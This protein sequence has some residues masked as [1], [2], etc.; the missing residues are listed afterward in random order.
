MDKKVD[1]KTLLSFAIK[2]KASDL[3][4]TT[5]TVPMLRLNGKIRTIQ[6][7]AMTSEDVTDTLTDVM[8][9]EQYQEFQSEQEI[10][11]A[12]D[13][14][15]GARFRVNAFH[16]I[17]GPAA[18]FR[19]I[20][21]KVPRLDDL[22]TPEIFKKFASLDKGLILVTGATGFGKSTTLAAM[23]D[24]INE[25][26]AKHILT[27]EDPVEFIH[28]PKNCLINHREVGGST[29]SFSKA[30]KSALRESPDVILVGEMRDLE[31]ISLALTAAETGHLVLGTLHT[32]SAP[33]TINRIIDVFPSGDKTM[34]RSM[35]ASSLQAV[36]AQT[37]LPTMDKKGR[38]AAF[39]VLVCNS[40]V[41]NLIREDQIPQIYSIMQVGHR[42]GMQT[43]QKAIEDLVDEK[44]V[45]PSELDRFSRKTED[46]E[47]S[48]VKKPE[49][50]EEE[51][52]QEKIE[53]VIRDN[54][55]QE[56][57]KPTLD[58]SKIAQ[59]SLEEDLDETI[60]IEGA[61]SLL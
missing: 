8:N 52:K 6:V 41:R 22:G 54:R 34:V 39:E 60:N 49:K 9:D 40:A 50:V 21:T 18:V 15:L 51:E 56:H 44:K 32:S 19:T 53:T 31:T 47:T 38:V 29:K 24:Y 55:A 61:T 59:E 10:D 58:F 4:I 11:F 27:I 26:T 28:G 42:F 30:L 43:M 2:N 1:I 35:L 3:F 13:L 45:S 12:I 17:A 48:V 46:V 25:N 23:I 5:D 7:A 16:T 37:L 33:Q 14:G 20:P 36:I 57:E